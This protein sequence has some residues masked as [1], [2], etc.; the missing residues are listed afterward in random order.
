MEDYPTKSETEEVNME[1]LDS[2]TG[3]QE[4]KSSMQE[5][6]V[7]VQQLRAR[8]Q[9]ADK[10]LIQSQYALDITDL[11]PKKCNKSRGK[12]R[13]I[14]W[15][16]AA[17]SSNEEKDRQPLYIDSDSELKKVQEKLQKKIVD[18]KALLIT[19]RE[20]L[21]KFNA[22]ERENEAHCKQKKDLEITKLTLET[23]LAKSTKETILAHEKAFI[24]ESQLKA[25]IMNV[26]EFPDLTLE[27][28]ATRAD[29]ERREKSEKKLKKSLNEA[30][31]MLNSLRSHVLSE[32]KEK[33]K[34]KRRLKLS[35]SKGSDS[36]TSTNSSGSELIAMMQSPDSDRR[37]DQAMILQLKS[38]I[39]AMEHQISCLQERVQDME[40]FRPTSTGLRS[41]QEQ[42]HELEEQVREAESA[43]E[44][45]TFM[46]EEVSDINKELLNDLKETETD[47]LECFEDLKIVK[48]K[49]KISQEEI[50]NAKYIAATAIRKI[51][52]LI[53][54]ERDKGSTVSGSS[55][56]RSFG[57]IRSCNPRTLTGY[58]NKLSEHVNIVMERN[59]VV[60]GS[61]GERI[62]SKV[63]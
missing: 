41:D 44:A 36:N 1:Y 52:E 31:N 37:E 63:F 53:D 23:E 40:A 19:I 62:E 16:N 25:S 9:A 45:T 47:G 59:S 11:T 46:L 57:S 38:H 27:L 13:D 17:Q 6:Q 55:G 42:I 32:E 21:N 33:K 29:L 61:F 26:G 48:E 39:L 28:Q 12:E 10:E 50:D 14:S 5:L 7:G 35:S 15:G 30:V 3:L 24:L 18:E 58:I 60:D 22:I 54:K 49:L 51:D 4:E 43:Y 2:A 34:W 56:A 8:L 20:S